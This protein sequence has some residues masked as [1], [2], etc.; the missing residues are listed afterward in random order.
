MRRIKLLAD[1][2]GHKNGEV[3]FVTPNEAHGLIDS[4]RAKLTKDMT[5]ADIKIKEVG[6]NG[7]KIRVSMPVVQK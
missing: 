4:G 7:Y 2:Q 6:S 3:I 5:S 1:W